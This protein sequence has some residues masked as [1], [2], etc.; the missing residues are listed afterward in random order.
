MLAV[1]GIG[2]VSALGLDATTSCAAARAGVQRV[3]QVDDVHV[4]DE[5]AEGAV[6]V[7]ACRVPIISR[8]LFGFAR[9]L[10]LAISAVDDLRRAS[11]TPRDRPVGV[12]LV[13]GSEPHRAA[14]LDRLRQDPDLSNDDTDPATAER[15]L[16]IHRLRLTEALLPN[17]VERA[18]IAIEPRAQRTILGD[19]VGFVSAVEQAAAWLANGMCETCWVGGVDSYLDPAT[20]EAL[21]GLGLLRTPTTPVGLMPGELACFLALERSDRQRG[22]ALAVIES[23]AQAEGA[24]NRLSYEGPNARPLMQAML[25]AGGSRSMEFGVVNL[26]GDTVR[27]SEWGTALVGRRSQGLAGQASTWVPPLYFG[28]IGAA[29][30][31]A[32]IAL[33][34]QGWARGYAPASKAL[35]C[36]MEDGASRGALSVSAY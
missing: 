27:A 14:W 16:T 9:R 36:L 10:Q 30:G 22:K 24:G 31:P 4:E 33:L 13:L 29:T 8:G 32:S 21:A 7:A 2:M 6:P 28:E 1:T 17:I 25:D 23:F 5:E 19:Q 18:Q 11:E 34:A 26:N 12:I 3:A 20:L 35:V 15:A